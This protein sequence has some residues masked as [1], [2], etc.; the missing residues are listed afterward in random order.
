MRREPELLQA[1]AH[2]VPEASGIGPMWEAHDEANGGAIPPLHSLRHLLPTRQG[3]SGDL[4]RPG[5][6]D[7]PKYSSTSSVA[8]T[9]TM[10]APSSAPVLRG[11][12]LKSLLRRIHDRTTRQWYPDGS[13]STV[14]RG[15]IRLCQFSRRAAS[16]IQAVAR[17]CKA[18]AVRA[19]VP[20]ALHRT[21]NDVASSGIVVTAAVACRLMRDFSSQASLDIGLFDAP[22]VL[23]KSVVIRHNSADATGGLAKPEAAGC[24]LG[25]PGQ[26]RREH[27]RW[28]GRVI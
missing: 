28:A 10:G 11:G 1:F 18:I 8:S 2:R 13:A 17:T 6:S 20:P 25:R 4:P 27:V 21:G 23:L 26:G 12:R 16:Y 24:I 14:A 7:C 3:R 22:M 15:S 5:S 19:R 9:A